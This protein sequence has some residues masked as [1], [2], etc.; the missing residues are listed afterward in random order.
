M[1]YDELQQAAIRAEFETGKREPSDAA[2]RSHVLVRLGR[3]GVGTL[4]CV[5]GIAML[6][7][8]GPGMLVLAA[9]LVILA[10]DVA[11]AD[12]ALRYVRKRTPG[13]P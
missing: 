1:D 12:R 13:I 11:W 3:M 5:A 7:L 8:P 9:G 4:L 10:E 2:A 6:V